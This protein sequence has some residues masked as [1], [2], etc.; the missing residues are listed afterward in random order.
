MEQSKESERKIPVVE[1]EKSTVVLSENSG[2]S[3]LG[4]ELRNNEAGSSLGNLILN[5]S[6]K[7][8][9]EDVE[10]STP[11]RQLIFQAQ[12]E[13]ALHAQAQILISPFTTH[14][15]DQNSAN[16]SLGPR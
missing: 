8:N 2:K 3:Q 4:M 15:A 13:P 16:H 6:E 5:F 9:Q 10:W 11:K 1:V 7:S 12:Q 14:K